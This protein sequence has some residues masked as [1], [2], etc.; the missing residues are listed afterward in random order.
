L[1]Y[2]SGGDDTGIGDVS[3]AAKA[4]LQD[5]D[6]LSRDTAVAARVVVNVAGQSSFSQGN[7]AGVGLSVSRRLL[8]RLVFHGDLHS[9]VAFD[10]TSRWNVPLRR[11]S[12]GF[13]AGPELALGRNSSVSLQYEGNT[14][15]YLSTGTAA[16]DEAYGDVTIGFAH[17]FGAARQAVVAHVYARENMNLPFSI[18]WNTDPDLAVGIRLTVRR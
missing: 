2:R 4:V 12:A 15:P 1:L 11:M 3:L 13:S 8:Q 6:P 18:R 9:T 5:A 7:F 14:T 10:R 16:L 17:R